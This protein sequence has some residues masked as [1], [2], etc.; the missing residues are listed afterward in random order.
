[1]D[2]IKEL[3]EEHLEIVETLTRVEQLGISPTDAQRKLVVAKDMIVSHVEKEDKFFYP[4][5]IEAVTGDRMMGR[6]V[7]MLS[8]GMQDI[9]E[10]V[11]GFFTSYADGGAGIE[12]IVAFGELFALVKSRVRREEEIL[13]PEFERAVHEP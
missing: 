13:F 11:F 9:S 2:L 4:V 8:Q 6:L 1:M 7:D 10:Y 12:F 3:K 5:L